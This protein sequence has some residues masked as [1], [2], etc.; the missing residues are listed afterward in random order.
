[1]DGLRVKLNIGAD[2]PF[3]MQ[4]YFLLLLFFIATNLYAQPGSDDLSLEVFDEKN[5]PASG[6][7][8]ELLNAADSSL[9]KTGVTDVKGRVSFPHLKKGSYVLRL[10][11][12]GYGITQTK[13][14]NLPQ[15]GLVQKINLNPLS[16]TLKSVTVTA[17]KPFIQQLRGKTVVNVDAAITNAGTTVLEVLEKSPGV[18]I[19]KNGSISLQAK[20]GVLV[21][22][23]DKP[24]YLAG[25]DLINMLSGMS[26]SQVDQMERSAGITVSQ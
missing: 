19:D 6:T 11:H 1:M 14:F 13:I 3:C 15:D 7:N 9:L 4:K 18:M 20:A 26:S 17:T 16:K 21:M 24:T 5:Q 8:V 12:S 10:S 23:D 22:I 25:T 2:N